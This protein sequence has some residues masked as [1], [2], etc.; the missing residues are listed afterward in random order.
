MKKR[1]YYKKSKYYSIYWWRGIIVCDNWKNDF[2]KF[3]D[4]M[5]EWYSKWLQIDRKD[6]DGNYC[7]D[8]CK[9]ST[10]KQNVRN[11]GITLFHS[12][13]ISMGEYAEKNDI[14]YD[15]ARYQDKRIEKIKLQKVYYYK[16]RDKIN[17]RRKQ[18]RLLKICNSDSTK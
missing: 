3:H 9:W 8:N 1:C 15:K 4:D 11:R 13:W 18:L 5:I 16:N 10:P 12:S 14:S 2:K 7:K 6:N 17:I